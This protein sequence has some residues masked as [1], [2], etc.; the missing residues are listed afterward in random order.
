MKAP[1]FTHM[2]VV[3]YLRGADE[4][5][6]EFV[7]VS[8]RHCWEHS[9]HCANHDYK[10]SGVTARCCALDV[11][12][13]RASPRL[14]PRRALLEGGGPWRMWDP[15]GKSEA[16]V[17]FLQRRVQRASFAS[18]PQDY[19]L[20]FGQHHGSKSNVIGDRNPAMQRTGL[21]CSLESSYSQR[22]SSV[23][24]L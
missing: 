18:W 22:C 12:S 9:Q 21:G 20:C 5:A 11:S 1:L 14:V 17:T 13:S 24:W 16:T 15:H 3:W 19:Q 8:A 4:E 23:C 2:L 6:F 10:G 7:M